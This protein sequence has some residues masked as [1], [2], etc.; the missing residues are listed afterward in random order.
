MPDCEIQRVSLK[1]LDRVITR[2]E[3]CGCF[4]SRENHMWIAVDNSTGDAW[5]EEFQSKRQAVRWH[6]NQFPKASNKSSKRLGF[7][8]ASNMMWDSGRF[9][10]HFPL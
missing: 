9:F 10:A 6:G 4:L 1:N 5:T 8:R 7:K 3:P 2:R